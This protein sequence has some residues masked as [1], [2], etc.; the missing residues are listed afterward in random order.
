MSPSP[1]Q[2]GPYAPELQPPHPP[3]SP[4][5]KTCTRARSFLSTLPAATPPTPG[6]NV[7]PLANTLDN[8]QQLRWWAQCVGHG[9]SAGLSPHLTP[10][11]PLACELSSPKGCSAFSLTR[12]VCVCVCLS[13]YLLSPHTHHSRGQDTHTHTHPGKG[14]ILRSGQVN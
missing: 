3:N 6:P 10:V 12:S 14:C 11:W 4:C 1:L 7:P 5:H 9:S 2:V 13:L 8:W